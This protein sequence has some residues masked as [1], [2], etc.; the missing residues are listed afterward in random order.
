MA[1]AT[2]GC[3]R[4]SWKLIVTAH[5]HAANK[6]SSKQVQSD[7]SMII[8]VPTFREDYREMLKKLT[9]TLGDEAKRRVKSLKDKT[10][11]MADA[12]KPDRVLS[13]AD[14][15]TGERCAVGEMTLAQ[16]SGNIETR[17]LVFQKSFVAALLDNFDDRIQNPRVALLLRLLH[18][19]EQRLS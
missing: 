10:L 4:F 8:D 14:A 18:L 1:A 12:G 3:A 19:R 16:A 9:V 17:L 6:C 5:I 11:V 2:D 7:S 13:V 15:E